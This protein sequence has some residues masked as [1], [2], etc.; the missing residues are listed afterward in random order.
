MSSTGGSEGRRDLCRRE[1]GNSIG[2][3]EGGKEGV[4]EEVN[5]EVG[6]ERVN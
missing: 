1:G 3:K 6:R 4:K 5:S 2:R